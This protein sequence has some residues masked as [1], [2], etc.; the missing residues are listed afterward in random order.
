[1]SFIYNGDWIAALLRSIQRMDY[2]QAENIPVKP[3]RTLRMLKASLRASPLEFEIP[4]PVLRH[5]GVPSG[6]NAK[7]RVFR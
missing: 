6:G 2:F 1:M 5:Q 7:M 4:V 3:S